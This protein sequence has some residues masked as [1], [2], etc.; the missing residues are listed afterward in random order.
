MKATTDKKYNNNLCF[1]AD[2]KQ[3]YP[4]LSVYEQ[5]G[6]Q[7]HDAGFDAFMTGLVF[8]TFAKFIEIGNIINKKFGDEGL[9][10]NSQPMTKAKKREELEKLGLPNNKRNR[11]NLEKDT[12]ITENARNI[13]HFSAVQNKPIYQ[14]DISR[15][16]NQVML[17]IDVPI[18]WSLNPSDP[19]THAEQAYAKKLQET[20]LYIRLKQSGKKDSF[21]RPIGV[22]SVYKVA[23]LFTK[24]GDVNIIKN[25]KFSCFLEI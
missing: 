13:K 17:N 20:V 25:T 16:S 14:E 1:E 9:P 11:K 15:F 2:L 23:E 5:N 22:P 24:F 6:G 4:I 10:K 12:S 7:G 21:G 18:F 8:A 3:Q 19:V